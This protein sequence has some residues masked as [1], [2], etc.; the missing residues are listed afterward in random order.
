MRGLL[1]AFPA[2]H[3]GGPVLE[4]SDSL[5]WQDFGVQGSNDTLQAPAARQTS[6]LHLTPLRL[7]GCK[8]WFGGKTPALHNYCLL[9]RLER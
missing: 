2:R 4:V 6:N 9:D 7:V 1:L 5:A 8:Q 3:E